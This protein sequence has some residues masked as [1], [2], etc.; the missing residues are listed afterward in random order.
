MMMLVR[1]AATPQ[2]WPLC[3]ALSLECLQPIIKEI[4]LAPSLFFQP[5]KFA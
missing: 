3:L 5:T 4:S 1:A 2:Q